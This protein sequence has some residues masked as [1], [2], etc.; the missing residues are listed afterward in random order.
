MAQPQPTSKP[1]RKQRMV[2][3]P[4]NAYIV[5]N[6]P[7]PLP[8]DCKNG[9]WASRPWRLGGHVVTY[10]QAIQWALNTGKL[11]K[12]DIVLGWDR[13]DCAARETNKFLVILSGDGSEGSDKLG[14]GDLLFVSRVAYFPQGYAGMTNFPKFKFNSKDQEAKEFLE[15]HGIMDTPYVTRLYEYNPV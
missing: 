11:A 15:S 2:H 5:Y 1:R 6:A 14:G 7:N 9:V 13:L 3:L 10:D 12:P 8:K 4:A